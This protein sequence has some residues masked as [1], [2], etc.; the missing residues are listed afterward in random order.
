VHTKITSGFGN[1]TFYYLKDFALRCSAP[2]VLQRHIFVSA[3]VCVSVC[4][5]LCVGVGVGVGVCV[6]LYLWMYVRTYVYVYMYV[7]MYV[8]MDGC[9]D[10]C[11]CTHVRTYLCMYVFSP[12]WG[13]YV[14]VYIKGGSDTWYFQAWHSNTWDFNTWNFNILSHVKSLNFIWSRVQEHQS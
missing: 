4:V 2:Y 10:V 3:R 11:V 9:M 6:C 12:H 8:W 7:C 5:C 14:H 13:T 1:N